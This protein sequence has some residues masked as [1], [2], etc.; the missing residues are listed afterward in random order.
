MQPKAQPSLHASKLGPSSS[1]ASPHFLVREHRADVPCQRVSVLSHLYRE[2][3]PRS[4]VACHYTLWQISVWLLGFACSGGLCGK[5]SLSHIW[6]KQQQLVQCGTDVPWPWS[7]PLISLEVVLGSLV[8]IPIILL[9]NLYLIL[10]LLTERWAIVLQ[11]QF[12][13]I[14][15]KALQKSHFNSVT[16]TVHSFQPDCLI[17]ISL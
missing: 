13:T 1:L 12:I 3:Y 6:L 17:T 7:S 8:I 16:H 10:L 15:S 11:R 4:F 5:L 14:V 2:H 9:F